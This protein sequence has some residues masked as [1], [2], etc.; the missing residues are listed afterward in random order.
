M[1]ESAAI[2]II[3]MLQNEGADVRAY[4]PQAMSQAE[5]ELRTVKYCGDPYEVAEGCDALV[6]AT[7]WDQFRYLDW[8]ASAP[9]CV[10]TS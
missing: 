2:D 4:D 6:L 10:A 9:R 8:A 5:R 3:R 1:R 7:E